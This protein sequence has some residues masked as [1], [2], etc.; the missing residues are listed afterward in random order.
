M[1]SKP[2]NKHQPKRSQRDEVKSPLGSLLRLTICLERCS[3]SWHTS[4]RR[5]PRW[6]L[7][8]CQLRGPRHPAATHVHQGYSNTHYQNIVLVQITALNSQ[9]GSS[10]CGHAGNV[11]NKSDACLRI[12]NFKV[13]FKVHNSLLYITIYQYIIIISIIKAFIIDI[14]GKFLFG[15]LVVE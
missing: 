7:L 1:S 3:G 13:S 11:E 15:H 9:E 14:N 12:C 4:C 5:P 8:W 10:E 2:N 6:K